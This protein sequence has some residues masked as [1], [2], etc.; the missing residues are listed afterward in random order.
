MIHA[1]PDYQEHYGE[2]PSGKIKADEPVF[3]ARAQDENFVRVLINYRN[4]ISINDNMPIEQRTQIVKQIDAHITLA[5]KWQAD[6]AGLVKTPDVPL[7][8][9]AD[10]KTA[11]AIHADD[12][13]K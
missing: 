10:V 2:D 8:P 5:E 4:L 6:N 11:Q 12:T 9:P 3:L 7:P 13:A 1:R